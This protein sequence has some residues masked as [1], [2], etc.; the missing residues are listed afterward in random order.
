MIWRLDAKSAPR[1]SGLPMSE[2]VIDLVKF[3]G[4]LFVELVEPKSFSRRVRVSR[5][6]VRIEKCLSFPQLARRGAWVVVVGG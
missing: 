3:N 2:S 4:P 1:V 5:P 6:A